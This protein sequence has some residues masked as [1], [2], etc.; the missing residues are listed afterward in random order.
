MSR[1]DYNKL[2]QE[3]KEE[4]D[5][6]WHSPGFDTETSAN[7]Q[8][9]IDRRIFSLQIAQSH[10]SAIEENS[11]LLKKLISLLKPKQ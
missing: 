4:S 9:E 8:N 11:T 5:A 1:L 7:R 3:L 10:E 2:I 6:I